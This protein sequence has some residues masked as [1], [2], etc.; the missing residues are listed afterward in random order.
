[1]WWGFKLVEMNVLLKDEFQLWWPRMMVVRVEIMVSSV[2]R[3]WW[4][5]GYGGGTVVGLGGSG[6]KERGRWRFLIW[7]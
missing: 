6:R 5:V 2:L 1:M 7:G 3:W 4:V